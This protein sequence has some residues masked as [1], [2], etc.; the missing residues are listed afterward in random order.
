MVLSGGRQ[1]GEAVALAFQDLSRREGGAFVDLRDAAPEP[2]VAAAELARAVAAYQAFDYGRAMGH[3][4]GAFDDAEKTGALGLSPEELCDLFIV[5]AMVRHGQGDA[6]AAWQDFVSAATIEPSRHLDAVRY[7]PSN[8]ASFERA[9]ELVSQGSLTELTI[10]SNAECSVFVDARKVASD[11][12]QRL[13]DGVHFV[14]VECPGS[15]AHVEQVKLTG[16]QRELQV[17]PTPV[18]A[19]TRTSLL[20][21]ATERGF[22]NLIWTHIVESPGAPPTAIFELLHADGSKVASTSIAIGEATET[23]RTA[24]LALSRL[25]DA[26]QPAPIEVV[27]V[28]R[29]TPWYRKPWFWA[30]VGAAASAAVILP[31][32]LQ[33]DPPVG[34]GVSLGGQGP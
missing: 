33:S 27:P 5:R 16:G 26:L 20:A 2:P 23:R 14:R 19:P 34:F 15:P 6:A 21:L 12:A 22:Q 18:P 1:V 3:L 9:R 8:V 29:P 25:L 13:P 11:Q 30:S 17:R 32:A 4:Q 24:L 10:S 31:F 28:T 7:S